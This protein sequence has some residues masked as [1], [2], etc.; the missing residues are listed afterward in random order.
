MSGLAAVARSI[1]AASS[2]EADQA[3]AQVDAHLRA[4]D[5]G[6][7]HGHALAPT[8]APAPQGEPP[9]PDEAMD[10]AM[11]PEGQAPQ[12][13]PGRALI[14]ALVQAPAGATRAPLPV[15]ARSGWAAACR[16]RSFGRQRNLGR[17]AAAIGSRADATTDTT[18]AAARRPHRLRTA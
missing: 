17:A 12:V 16:Q 6:H 2:L 3:N 8:L 10:D 4:V 1:S 11:A 7:Q 18:G 9:A 14:E 13:A 5:M 15:R